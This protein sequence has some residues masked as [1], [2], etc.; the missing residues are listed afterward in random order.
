M[1]SA[2]TRKDTMGKGK[3]PCIGCGKIHDDISEATEK[4]LRDLG[5]AITR[6]CN[7]C[8]DAET[9]L[10]ALISNVV[11]TA[12]NADY[13]LSDIAVMMMKS[14]GIAGG[15]P[16]KVAALEALLRLSTEEV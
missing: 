13:S 1:E 14:I 3:K 10:A 8:D 6:L 16:G 9:V 4:E 12:K 5:D 15:V 2:T 11:L 7:E